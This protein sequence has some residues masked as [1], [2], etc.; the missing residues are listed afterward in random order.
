MPPFV[1]D[2][3]LELFMETELEQRDEPKAA[4]RAVASLI[5]CRILNLT[6][7]FMLVYCVNVEKF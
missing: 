4:V 7:D 1:V 3:G 6:T 5:R 2:G